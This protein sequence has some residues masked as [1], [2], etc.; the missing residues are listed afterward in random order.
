MSA[1]RTP[2][3]VFASSGENPFDFK[4]NSGEIMSSGPAKEALEEL[5]V[6][7]RRKLPNK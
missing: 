5:R 6:A 3:Y 7:A 4:V 1:D 2:E